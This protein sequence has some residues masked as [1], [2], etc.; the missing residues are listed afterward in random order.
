MEEISIQ[1]VYSHTPTPTT[2]QYFLEVLSMWDFSTESL[3]TQW[4]VSL[5][6]LRSCCLWLYWCRWA[7]GDGVV[8]HYPSI[9]PSSFNTRRKQWCGIKDGNREHTRIWEYPE[10]L[11]KDIYIH[12]IVLYNLYTKIYYMC[13]CR[14]YIAFAHI[15]DIH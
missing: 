1:Y 14:N 13:L 7:F 10:S 9:I 15:N 6:E 11:E 4:L 8:L 3:V 2:L 5:F 12:I